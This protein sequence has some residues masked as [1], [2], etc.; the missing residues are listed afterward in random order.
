M[1]KKGFIPFFMPFVPDG[2]PLPLASTAPLN[3]ADTRPQNQNPSWPVHFSFA[4]Q[5]RTLTSLT[6]KI[7]MLSARHRTQSQAPSH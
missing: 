6:S 5:I 2:I 3:Q 4:P 7:Q 1:S